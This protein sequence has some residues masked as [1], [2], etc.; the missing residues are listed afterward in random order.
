[1]CAAI[2]LYAQ[3]ERNT[4]V[5]ALLDLAKTRT[6]CA[7]WWRLPLGSMMQRRGYQLPCCS[8][9]APRHGEARAQQNRP[10]SYQ[11]VSRLFLR[12]ED[13]WPQ[14]STP[15]VKKRFF[16]QI[17]KAGRMK[18]AS[19]SKR[20]ATALSLCPDVVLS[21]QG[22]ISKTGAPAQGRIPAVPRGGVG[23]VPTGVPPRC[24]TPGVAFLRA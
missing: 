5:R 17:N 18:A 15:R 3:S 23:L 21:L 13:F 8:A 10:N 19:I 6:F 9:A 14:N 22:V 16:T 11:N 4:H 1:M 20:F 12:L 2:Y 24:L 7:K